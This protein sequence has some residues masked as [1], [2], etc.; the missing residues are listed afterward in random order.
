MC[1]QDVMSNLSWSER[2]A[3][4]QRYDAMHENLIEKLSWTILAGY[5][6]LD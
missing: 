6:T 2:R 1:F 4:D 3:H 5:G